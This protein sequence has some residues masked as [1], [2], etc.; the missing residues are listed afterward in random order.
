MSATGSGYDFLLDKPVALPKLSEARK[1]YY[2]MNGKVANKRFA[3]YT[4]RVV[5]EVV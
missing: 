3:G 2:E 5:S 1:T 4:S